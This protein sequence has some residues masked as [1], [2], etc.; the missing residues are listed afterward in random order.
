MPTIDTDSKLEL[1]LGSQLPPE[2]RK[3]DMSLRESFNDHAGRYIGKID[4]FFDVYEKH[5]S[6][7]R[8]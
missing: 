7:Y 1:T 8:E 6:R 2:K 5:F 3:Q 4:H